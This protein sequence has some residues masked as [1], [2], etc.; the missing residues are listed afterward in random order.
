MKDIVVVVAFAATTVI[1][2]SALGLDSGTSLGDSIFRIILSAIFGVVLGYLIRLYMRYLNAELLL[3][4]ITM[5]YTVSFICDV[6]HLESALLFIAAGFIVANGPDKGGHFISESDVHSCIRCF[7]YHCRSIHLDVLVGMALF[8]FYWLEYERWH[9]GCIRGCINRYG[10]QRICLDGFVSQAGA[11]TLVTVLFPYTVLDGRST[12]L[13][14]LGWGRK[15]LW[16][17]H[18]FNQHCKSRGSTIE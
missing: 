5:I 6:F 12:F 9:L 8:A 13:F 16:V 4:V 3:F 11:I 15:K 7:L 10:H 2:T 18:Y 1:A 14:Y 17:K